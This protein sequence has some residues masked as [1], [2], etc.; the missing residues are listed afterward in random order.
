MCGH[1]TKDAVALCL[2]ERVGNEGQEFKSFQTN[3]SGIQNHS[4]G[5]TPPWEF[6]TFICSQSDRLRMASFRLWRRACDLEERADNMEKRPPDLKQTE[7]MQ[8]ARE[9]QQRHGLI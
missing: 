5:D 1:C 4:E 3:P 7:L 6:D 8:A 9:M 2:R